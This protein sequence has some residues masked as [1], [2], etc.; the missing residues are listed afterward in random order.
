MEEHGSCCRV[1]RLEVAGVSNSCPSI[2][3]GRDFVTVVMAPRVAVRVD[4]ILVKMA[5]RCDFL[6]TENS[7]EVEYDPFWG[8]AKPLQNGKRAVRKVAFE[9]GIC[10]LGHVY[11][12]RRYREMSSYDENRGKTSEN[13]FRSTFFSSVWK[14]AESA[15]TR[16]NFSENVPPNFL[17]FVPNI[18]KAIVLYCCSIASKLVLLLH[19]YDYYSE[20]LV[21]M[22]ENRGFCEKTEFF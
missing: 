13:V 9:E 1:L 11:E 14:R 20:E 15:G 18:G 2:A 7:V 6:A 16:D 17:G 19:D 3:S 21:G 8:G 10:D 4:Y 5:L 12:S 22:F